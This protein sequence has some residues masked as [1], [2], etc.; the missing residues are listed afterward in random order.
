[1][2]GRNRLLIFLYSRRNV[3]GS[4][5]AILG[6]GAYLT[7]FIDQFWLPIVA[8]L[9]AIGYLATPAAPAL[10]FGAPTGNSPAEIQAFL[11]SL[12]DRVRDALEPR[13]SQRVMSI[14]ASINQALPELSRGAAQT[15]GTLFT[16]RQIAVDYL[17]SAL[18]TYL[19]LPPAYRVRHTVENRKTPQDLLEEQ[20]TLLDGKMQEVLVSVHENDVQ[21]LLTNGRFLKEK[22]AEPVFKVTAI[23]DSSGT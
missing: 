10:F 12:V 9:Y 1:M 5:L 7:G 6:L 23:G 21:A 19:K 14:V 17:P 3:V 4:V 16:V 18:N 2:S 8:G 11:A 15:D 22:F 20:L 13:V